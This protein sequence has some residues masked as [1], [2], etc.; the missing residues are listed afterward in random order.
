[1]STARQ[2]QILRALEEGLSQQRVAD[3]VHIS[4][5]VVNRDL[6]SLRQALGM[7]TTTQVLIWWGG[8][9]ERLLP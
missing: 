8:T 3:R 6:S 7:T 9:E 1:M 2:R 5:R 4:D